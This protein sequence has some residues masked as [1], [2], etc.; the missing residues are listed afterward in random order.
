MR[1]FGQ[2]IPGMVKEMYRELYDTPSK[3]PEPD[4]SAGNPTNRQGRDDKGRQKHG[5]VE[6]DPTFAAAFER[7]QVQK[8]KNFD[9]AIHM[10][11]VGL[12]LHIE[13]ALNLLMS[14][15]E[16]DARKDGP[17]GAE[18]ET[19][20]NYLVDRAA[21]TVNGYAQRQHLK[22]LAAKE[23]RERSLGEQDE[24]KAAGIE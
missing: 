13:Q 6:S 4:Y 15:A 20:P 18:G 2:E 21:P 14:D 19:N 9:R 22:R 23:V 17:D 12:E 1:A 8:R 24:W 7:R 11:T 3:E 5:Y 10:L 16:K